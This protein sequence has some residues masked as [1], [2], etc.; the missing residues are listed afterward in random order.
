MWVN[1]KVLE[2]IE[3]VLCIALSVLVVIAIYYV[4]QIKCDALGIDF[5]FYNA[6]FRW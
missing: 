2:W 6:V 5:N 1:V 3:I 4:A